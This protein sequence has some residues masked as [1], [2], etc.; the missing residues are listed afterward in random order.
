MW[1]TGCQGSSSRSSPNGD[2]RGAPDKVGG[3]ITLRSLASFDCIICL[4][5]G[6]DLH[7]TVSEERLP[8]VTSELANQVAKE[9][10]ASTERERTPDNTRIVTVERRHF[11][12]YQA[13]QD[14][15]I[16]K[17]EEYYEQF[18][19]AYVGDRVM[20]TDERDFGAREA[21]YDG[22]IQYYCARVVDD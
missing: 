19:A 18:I 7:M 5:C 1:Q 6:H 4:S 2:V 3:E 13:L 16:F 10:P 14:P 22:Y 17:D 11:P 8:K 21:G 12:D 20:V 9:E 15:L